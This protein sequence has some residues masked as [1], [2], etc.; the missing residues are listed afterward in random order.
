MV[1]HGS[2]IVI[3][4]DTMVDVVSMPP[5]F[6]RPSSVLD[7]TTPEISDIG[8]CVLIRPYES[9]SDIGFDDSRESLDGRNLTRT[10]RFEN[11]FKGKEGNQSI[12]R[13]FRW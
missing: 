7:S 1:F 12:H 11:F 9:G 3:I 5:R 6:G 4:A 2:R 10:W 13:E 8:C